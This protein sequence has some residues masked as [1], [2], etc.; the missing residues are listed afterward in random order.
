MWHFTKHINLYCPAAMLSN[1]NSAH[2]QL[3]HQ[4]FSESISTI[5]YN[6]ICKST[7]K[8]RYGINH[9]WHHHHRLPELLYYC[10]HHGNVHMQLSIQGYAFCKSS[11]WLNS[12]S[13][14]CILQSPVVLLGP[15]LCLWEWGRIVLSPLSNPIL[16]VPGSGP[17]TAAL[18]GKPVDCEI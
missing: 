3:H 14:N 18:E 15:L 2:S 1:T 17:S 5:L 9:H 4:C 6:Y 7:T 11:V 12:L 13:C 16:L 8:H 10:K